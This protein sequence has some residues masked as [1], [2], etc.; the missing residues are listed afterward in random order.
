MSSLHVSPYSLKILAHEGLLL[1]FGPSERI[2]DVTLNAP[3]FEQEVE[4]KPKL[5]LE[6]VYSP[7]S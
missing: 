1:S 2:A 7:I 5:E 4:F 3:E 6:H